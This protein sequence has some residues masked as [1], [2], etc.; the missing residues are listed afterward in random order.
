M[1]MMQVFVLHMRDKLL[2]LK[3]AGLPLL[4]SRY[5]VLPV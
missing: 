2:S 3:L 4:G 5:G 1:S